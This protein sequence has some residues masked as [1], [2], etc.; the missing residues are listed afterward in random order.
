MLEV[1]AAADRWVWD[2]VP[3]ADSGGHVHRSHPSCWV[4]PHPP[5]SSTHQPTHHHRQPRDTN[6]CASVATVPPPS[7]Y[8]VG[9]WS[10]RL[11]MFQMLP[12]AIKLPSRRANANT[13]S[14]PN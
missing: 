12:I 8:Y 11:H 3:R 14:C 2:E 4:T 1:L 9:I 5:P 6:I 10:D 13:R 7:R